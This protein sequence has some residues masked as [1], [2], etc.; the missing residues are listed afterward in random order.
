MRGPEKVA[1]PLVVIPRSPNLDCDGREDT[2]SVVRT[3]AGPGA[4]FPELLVRHAYGRTL[5]VQ[6]HLDGLPGII[7]LADL[8]GDGRLDLVLATA[9]ETIALSMTVVLVYPDSLIEAKEKEPSGVY[10][11]DPMD[12]PDCSLDSLTPRVKRL[13]S[14]RL[15][16]SWIV[17]G[18]SRRSQ[19]TCD[20]PPRGDWELVRNALRRLR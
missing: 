17:V 9:D 1:A 16:L 18:P 2:V 11:Y 8:N 6:L 15:A 20:A 5:T 4:G 3:D 13:P 10:Y 12:H 19:P 7:D 14:R